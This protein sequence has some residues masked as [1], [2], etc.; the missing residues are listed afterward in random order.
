M[1]ILFLAVLIGI[2]LFPSCNEELLNNDSSQVVN[3]N[4]VVSR[5]IKCRDK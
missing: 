4:K 2:F 3:D 1:K 5:R